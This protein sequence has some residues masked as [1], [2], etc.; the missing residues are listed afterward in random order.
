MTTKQIEKKQDSPLSI[1]RKTISSE[2]FLDQVTKALPRHVSADRFARM[3]VTAVNKTP[4]LAECSQASVLQCLMDLSSLGLEPGRLAHLIPYNCKEKINGKEQWVTKCQLIVDYKGIVELAMRSGEVSYIHADKICD[5]DSFEYNKG[6]IIEHKIDFKKD[7]GDVYAYYALIVMKD[8]TEKAEV[9]TISEI[10]EVRKRSKSKDNGP[11]V[12]DFGEMAKKTVFKRAS[13]WIRLSPELQDAIEKDDEDQAFEIGKAT[14][15]S[16]PLFDKNTIQIEGET[17]VVEENDDHESTPEE[18][19]EARDLAHLL[20]LMKADG[21]SQKDV[22]AYVYD[23]SSEKYASVAEM[24]AQL[25]GVII[26]DFKNVVAW[27]QKM[28]EATK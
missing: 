25:I 26:A 11:W 27:V 16:Q 2:T 7:R 1:L 21:I 5:N 28:K 12:T 22:C 20:A 9:M 4:K 18:S 15:V 17:E 23:G 6:K 3:A 13:K 8:G 14:V 10:E 19:K 24:S